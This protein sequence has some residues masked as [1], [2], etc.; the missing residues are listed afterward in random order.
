MESIEWNGIVR[1]NDFFLWR[2]WWI[3]SIR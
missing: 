2:A 1:L 3:P